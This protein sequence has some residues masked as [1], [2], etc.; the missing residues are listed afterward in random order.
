MSFKVAE[1]KSQLTGVK[2]GSTNVIDLSQD[3]L[4][5]VRGLVSYFYTLNYQLPV[6]QAAPTALSPLIGHV[7]MYAV[8]DR[9]DMECL[10]TLAKEKFKTLAKIDWKQDEFPAAV[11]EIYG[12]TLSTDRSLRNVAR[13]IVKENIEELLCNE[14]FVDVL[15]GAADLG[16]DLVKLFAL[17]PAPKKR[18]FS[19][20]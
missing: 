11:K 8:A 13:D 10:K 16:L 3:D 12:T 19:G 6:E 4:D 7:R 17:P 9:L 14:H 20:R 5:V 15:G 2:E 1:I 18:T